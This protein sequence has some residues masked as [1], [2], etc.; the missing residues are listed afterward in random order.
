M[1]NY[2]EKQI[3]RLFAFG[4]NT[5][6][7]SDYNQH[8]RP[9]DAPQPS[10]TYNMATYMNLGGRRFAYPSLFGAIQKFFD[11]TIILAGMYNYTQI[12]NRLGLTNSDLELGISQYGTGIGSADHADRS[13]IF[14][15]T[16]FTLNTSTIM[17]HVSNNGV[18][19]ITGLEVRAS[20]D[21][22]DFDA[23]NLLSELVNTAILEPTFDPYGLSRGEV[24]INYT[25]SG[26]TY[27]TY[28]EANFNAHRTLEDDVSVIGSP[29]K[30]TKDALGIARLPVNGGIQ[31]FQN[32]ASDPF[33]SYRKDGNIKV[34]YGT[35]ADDGIVSFGLRRDF[36][37][38]FGVL[39]V[40]GPGDDSLTAEESFDELLGGFGNDT[41]RGG[42]GSDTLNGEEGNDSLEGGF[43]SDTLNG[44]EGN[45]S[46][47][48]GFDNDSLN[49]G[50]GNDT[51]EGDDNN[52]SLNGGEGND[53]LEGGAGHDTL[54]GGAGE[55]TIDGGSF[56][57]SGND[58]AVYQG[59]SDEYDFTFQ[60]DGSIRIH[61]NAAGRDGTD[62]LKG[63]EKAVFADKTIDLRPGH[64][65][66]FVIDTTGSMADD[67]AA[68]RTGINDIINSV[69]VLF[70]NS[71]IG[72]VGY[73]DPGTNTFLSF[74]NQPSIEARKTAVINAINSISVGGGGDFPEA[75]NAGLLR[76]LSGGAGEWRP[77]AAARRIILFGDAPP[78]DNHLRSQVL[79]LASN[80]GTSIASSA[81]T[82]SSLS[83]DVSLTNL[84]VTTTNEEGTSTVSVQ[85]FTIQIGNDP[86]TAQDFTS[87]AT[88][89]G[90]E[91]FNAANASEV[92]D[93][94]IEA[95]ET[96]IG[97]P[98]TVATPIPNQATDENTPF[99]LTVSPN[100]FADADAG[101]TL[102][103]SAEDLPGWLSFDST[104]NTFS[105]TPSDTDI[106]KIDITVTATDS[107]NNT[108]SDTFSLNV[109]NV[110]IGDELNNTLYGSLYDD[111]IEGL[112]GKDTIFSG[113][114]DDIIDGGSDLDR[115]YG[116]SSDDTLDGGSGDDRLFGGYDNDYLLGGDGEDRLYGDI[117]DD[118]LDGGSEDDR[119]FGSTGNDSLLGGDGR[120][121]LYGGSGNDILDG[122]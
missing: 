6:S 61:D 91:T 22:F 77:E 15:S 54:M 40:G 47:K 23:G 69:F 92:V 14:G 26:K 120:D 90:G 32:I 9:L 4:T 51:L 113:S 30:R 49:G 80:L 11:S 56:L 63:V 66:V 111:K 79:A 50:E 28:T 93:R 41:L 76:A 16:S 107:S 37:T 7:Q 74:T 52:D 21:N 105:G 82:T 89:T 106:G 68:V 102:T 38:Y 83:S 12:Q 73:N 119:L 35:P 115:I 57:G 27:N 87:L 122:G 104:T 58:R 65:I 8:I 1:S 29:S 70:P 108:V 101:D 62:T 81:I 97:T 45:D 3:T 2:D 24:A 19:S 109:I 114:G 72:V 75:V 85:I 64:D 10:I 118:T 84:E 88:S 5:P 94:L 103:L 46:L 95:I 98:P 25:G 55:D 60:N 42:L 36:E 59:V 18:K 31:Y 78:K 116:Q 20:E 96:P 71:R 17:F 117:G 67:I 53:S 110:V 43:G 48:G 13:Y 112:G 121:R 99:T 34:I 44:G 33:L 86:T 39:I 100:T